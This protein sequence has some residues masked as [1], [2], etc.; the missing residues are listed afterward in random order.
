MTSK[1]T[2]NTIEN[3]LKPE[4]PIDLYHILSV[5]KRKEY[6]G[7]LRNEIVNNIM[8]A[9]RYSRKYPNAYKLNLIVNK[10]M[11]ENIN[12]NLEEIALNIKYMSQT[13]EDQK[14]EI[15][16]QRKQ[17]EYQLKNQRKE[18]EEELRQIKNYNSMQQKKIEESLK[19]LKELKEYNNLQKEK[20][21]KFIIKN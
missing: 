3:L 14:R 15:E 17:F 19:E 2:P 12:M 20:L 1:Y 8:E 21:T 9:E 10:E 18:I 7:N 4:S 6:V 5:K 11:G 13:I 16:E